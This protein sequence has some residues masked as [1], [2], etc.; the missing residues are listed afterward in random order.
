M[1]NLGSNAADVRIYFLT[2]LRRYAALFLLCLRAAVSSVGVRH[3]AQLNIFN[4]RGSL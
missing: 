3:L 4:C 1:A 2:A